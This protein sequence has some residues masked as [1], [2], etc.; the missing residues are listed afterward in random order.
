MMNQHQQT[1]YKFK[2]KRT[3]K[4]NQK[5]Q[6]KKQKKQK[7]FPRLLAKEYVKSILTK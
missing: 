7:T 6:K 4:E 1:H 2:Y 5:N 3:K